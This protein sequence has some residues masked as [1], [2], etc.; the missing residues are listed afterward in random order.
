MK[1]RETASPHHT[2][3]ILIEVG[4]LKSQG[5]ESKATFLNSNHIIDLTL[6]VNVPG[7]AVYRMRE[8]ASRLRHR[9]R[10]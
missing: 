10:T 5:Q 7:D 3:L 4:K 9:H 8:E 1:A 6:D 2:L